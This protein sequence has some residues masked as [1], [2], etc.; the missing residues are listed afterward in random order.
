MESSLTVSSWQQ[1]FGSFGDYL[2]TWHVQSCSALH[3]LKHW[4]Y[5]LTQLLLEQPTN[6]S[7]WNFVLRVFR[8][9]CLS[10]RSHLR[11]SLARQLSP[12]CRPATE[13]PC[14]NAN[15][16]V[17]KERLIDLSTLCV[18]HHLLKSD[19]KVWQVRVTVPL[20]SQYFLNSNILFNMTMTV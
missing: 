12:H 6:S 15:L 14:T 10:E 5:D 16:G 13:V 17:M 7:F 11:V 20:I 2:L 1:M 9:S 19:T 8:K 4:K 3:M 18:H